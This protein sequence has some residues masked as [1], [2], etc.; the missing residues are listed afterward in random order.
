MKLSFSPLIPIMIAAA[1]FTHSLEIL[2]LTYS[3][4]LLHEIA[5]LVAAICIG[6][7]AEKLSFSP[8]GVRLTLK[9]KLI[10]SMSDEII[11]YAAGPLLNGILAVVFL[12]IGYERLYVMNTVLFVMNLLPVMPLDGGVIIKRILSWQMGER[13]AKRIMC[14]FSVIISAAFISAAFIGLSKG[15]VNVSLFV[16]ALFLLGNIISGNELYRAD[17]VN[18]LSKNTKKTNKVKLVLVDEKHNILHAAHTLSPSY[19]T[20]AAVVENGKVKQLI[21]EHEI[22]ESITSSDISL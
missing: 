4:M 6:L 5:H 17:F 14:V 20:L 13:C 12:I 1:Y 8:F 10:R 3:I 9:N 7:K 19:T 21:T 16:M 18:A 22:I 15:I 11:L 2:L